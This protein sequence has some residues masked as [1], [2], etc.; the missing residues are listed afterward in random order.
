MCQLKFGIALVLRSNNKQLEFD[1]VVSKLMK[2]CAYQE[3]SIMEVAVKAKSLGLDQKKTEAALAILKADNFL[4]EG[5]FCRAFITG[6][7]N[8]K[9]WG[10][11]KIKAAL[12]QK[13]VDHELGSM[14]LREIL[15]SKIDEN[16]N[17]WIDYRLKRAPLEASNFNQHFQYIVSKGFDHD[18][19]YQ[20]LKS[21]IQ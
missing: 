12:Y 8:I 14:Y 7:L 3:R 18:S 19:V 21:M 5:R 11:Y 17:Y 2:F 20:K 1:E 6:K 15:E 10:P 9:K 4:D 13:G 16:L